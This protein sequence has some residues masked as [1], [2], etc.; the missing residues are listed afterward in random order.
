MLAT[1]M[2]Q[3]SSQAEPARHNIP[4]SVDERP[5][6]AV[7]PQLSQAGVRGVL[8]DPAEV[9]AH[10]RQGQPHRLG[11][12]VHLHKPPSHRGAGLPEPLLRRQALRP[13]SLTPEPHEGAN[14]HVEG[15]LRLTGHLD[16]AG[17]D[18][19]ELGAHRHRASV[20]RAVA[21]P[22]D[23]ALIVVVAEEAVQDLGAS[24]GLIGGNLGPSGIIAIEHNVKVVFIRGLELGTVQ[25]RPPALEPG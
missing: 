25:V 23:L 17:K 8:G 6:D 20:W 3:P 10:A 2:R 15:P 12:R 21:E 1:A 9:N 18:G 16:G 14:G 4:T 24:K 13:P 19:P 7:G 22:S 5:V 11:L